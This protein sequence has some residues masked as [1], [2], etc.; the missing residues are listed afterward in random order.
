MLCTLP[1]TPPGRLPGH[2]LSQEKEKEKKTPIDE[3]IE[4][5]EGLLA[6]QAVHV[7]HY[8]AMLARHICNCPATLVGELDVHLLQLTLQYAVTEDGAHL[9]ET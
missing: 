8:C 4:R 6:P 5:V 3:A 2:P 9:N 7:D 1:S